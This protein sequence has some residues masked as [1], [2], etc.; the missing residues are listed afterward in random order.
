MKLPEIIHFID[1]IER[2]F[3]MFA[4]HF[5]RAVIVIMSKRNRRST[6]LG[7]WLAFVALDKNCH[8]IP[9]IIYFVHG[10]NSLFDNNV[11]IACAVCN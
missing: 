10:L 7:L 6:E 9:I 4:K 5:L 1:S 3:V 11:W 8:P 2:N